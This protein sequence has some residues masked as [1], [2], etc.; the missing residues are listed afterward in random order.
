M[1]DRVRP[2]QSSTRRTAT[3]QA[4]LTVV[5]FAALGAVC[6]LVW[7]AVWEPP[8][9]VV[10]DGR[11]APT[12]AGYE[13]DA[14]GTVLYVLVGAPAGLALAALVAWL[15]DRVPLVTLAA[16]FVGSVLA[17]W[18]MLVVGLEAGP[19]DP[20]TLAGEAADGTEL[21]GRL[22]VHGA[23]PYAALPLGALTGLAMVYVFLP[24]RVSAAER[25]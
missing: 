19:P 14:D 9:G 22:E 24:S 8:V 25:G 16:V 7:E 13:A 5:L 3:W 17:A 18:L 11:W 1:L 10:R 4:L 23:A 6:G 12:L 20:S 21:P 2:A 15:L